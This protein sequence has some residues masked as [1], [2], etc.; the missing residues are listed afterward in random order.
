V[1]CVHVISIHTVEVTIG[2]VAAERAG[3]C[4]KQNRAH[5]RSY[6]QL[7][8]DLQLLERVGLVTRSADGRLT[9]PW[10]KIIAEIAL[11]A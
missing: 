9:A 3:N 10:K 5:S 4:F 8:N 7:R 11:A 1:Y 2:V 6:R